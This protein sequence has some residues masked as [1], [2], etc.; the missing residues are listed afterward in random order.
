M[1]PGVE[2]STGSLGHG[3]PISV[4]MALGAK[5]AGK[6]WRTYTL[7]GDGESDEGSNWEAAMA[8]A[9]FKLDNLVAIIDRN[10]LMMDGPTE[11]VMPLENFGDKWRAFGW[12]VI[13]INGNSIP[14]N[15]RRLRQGP[16]SQGEAH[17][18]HCQHHQ[19]L[20]H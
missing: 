3:L 8:G 17:R 18:H 2:I 12:E 1:V 9:E 19:G 7:L 4:G 14:G 15:R 5:L 20:R 6:K 13:E 11:D 16:R 10:K